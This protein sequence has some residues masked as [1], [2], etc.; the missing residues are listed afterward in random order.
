MDIYLIEAMIT[1]VIRSAT[2]LLLLGLGI[3]ISERAG[4]LNLGQEVCLLAAP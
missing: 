1:A 4:I 2:P 3:I